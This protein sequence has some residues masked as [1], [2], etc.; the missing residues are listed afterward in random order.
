LSDDGT[1]LKLDTA[2]SKKL[3]LA[4]MNDDL[5][6]SELTKLYYAGLAKDKMD[7]EEEGVAVVE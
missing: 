4:L 3:F 2:V 5:L 1:K 7:V 6:T